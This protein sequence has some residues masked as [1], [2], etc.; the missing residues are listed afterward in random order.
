MT[1]IGQWVET[2]R[3]LG[4]GDSPELRRLYGDVL[5]RTVLRPHRHYHTYQHIAECFEKV[6]TSSSWRNIHPRYMLASGSTM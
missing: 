2:W 4:V 5:A 3:E 1:E 6:K